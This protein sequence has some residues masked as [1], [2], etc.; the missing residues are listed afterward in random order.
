MPRIID[1]STENTKAF[2]G[3]YTSYKNA[4]EAARAES[5]F[6]L[7]LW[8]YTT[9]GEEMTR[10]LIRKETSND[11]NSQRLLYQLVVNKAEE[12]E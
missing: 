4:S 1:L 12:D 9:I 10:A 7:L 3:K 6:D 11:A 5:F 8:T 2:L